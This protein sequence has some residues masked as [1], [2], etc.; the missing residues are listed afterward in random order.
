[1]TNPRVFSCAATTSS[2]AHIPRRLCCNSTC[3]CP[4][5]H[6]F[7]FLA[8]HARIRISLVLL[9]YVVQE[10]ATTLYVHVDGS[11]SMYDFMIFV[12]N[13][14]DSLFLGV[15]LIISCGWQITRDSF[16]KRKF[17]FFFPP[18]HFGCSVTVDYILD[19][20]IGHANNKEEVR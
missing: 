19:K 9:I 17:I 1:M 18:I 8:Y 12:Y 4:V 13:L 11:D 6:A 3:V 15:L 20:H 5:A 10:V 2:R 16:D 7:L 14:A